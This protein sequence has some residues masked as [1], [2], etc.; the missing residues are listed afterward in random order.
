MRTIV[1]KL[2]DDSEYPT[3]IFTEPRV[4]YRMP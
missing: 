2:S 3:Y 4:E 1:G